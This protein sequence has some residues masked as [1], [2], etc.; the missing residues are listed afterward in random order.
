MD[1]KIF[2][3][4]PTIRNLDFL[5]SWEKEFK[6]LYGIIIEDHQEKNI[7]VPSNVFKKTYHYTWADINNN[8]KDKSWI[9]PR[10][11]SAIRSYG[12]LKAYEMGATR[13]ITIDDDC[14]PSEKDFVSKHIENLNAKVP[15]R[16]FPT[17]PVSGLWGTRGFPYGEEREQIKIEVSHGMWKRHLDLDAP[18]HLMKL[19]YEFNQDL[20]FNYFIPKNYYFPL[21]I[22]NVAFNR[23]VTPLFYMLLMGYHSK[24]SPFWF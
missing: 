8:L 22:M 10:K 23:S 3:V 5:S 16:W 24:T 21:C 7:Q 19:N 13:I 1:E 20:L 9:I 18:T 14:L 12:F 15:S 2:V 17:L 6:D 11:S 4:I